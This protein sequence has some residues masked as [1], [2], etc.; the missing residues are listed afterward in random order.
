MTLLDGTIFTKCNA[1]LDSIV[2]SHPLSKCSV[3]GLRQQTHPWPAMHHGPALVG[4]CARLSRSRRAR[5]KLCCGENSVINA[6][7]L[8]GPDGSRAHIIHGDATAPS[9][10]ATTNKRAQMTSARA[11]SMIRHWIFDHWDMFLPLPLDRLYQVK[12][13]SKSSRHY[14]SRS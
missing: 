14:R 10:Q 9:T 12:T 3:G 1:E 11:P 8:P 5:H 13:L 6:A 4:Q 7:L 2:A